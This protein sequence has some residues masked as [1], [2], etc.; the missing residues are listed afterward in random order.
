MNV[1]EQLSALIA[2]IY[3]AALDPAQRTDVI[4]KI[5]SFAGGHTGGL[6]SKNSLSSS[7]N[8]Y[9]YIGA[10]P[11]SLQVYSESYPKLDPTADLPSFGVEQVVS[12]ADLVPSEEFRR[13]AFIGSGRDRMGGSTL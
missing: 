3:D 13:A 4:E 8:L 1:S 6:L 12:P 10:D 9:R 7:E 2:D 11:E 5:A